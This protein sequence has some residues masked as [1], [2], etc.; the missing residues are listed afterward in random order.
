ML[1]II[2]KSKCEI[3]YSYCEREEFERICGERYF[4]ERVV[5]LF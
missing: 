2:F 3:S 1:V 5:W 4:F